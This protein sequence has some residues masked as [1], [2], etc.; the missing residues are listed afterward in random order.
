MTLCLIRLNETMK[1][2]LPKISYL[3]NLG[4]EDKSVK[5][6]LARGD[7]CSN[8]TA[9]HQ[10]RNVVLIYIKSKNYVKQQVFIDVY[11]AKI[12]NKLFCETL[13]FEFYHLCILLFIPCLFQR[14]Y[15]TKYMYLNA[16]HKCVY[17]I[18][19]NLLCTK[20]TKL[21]KPKLNAFDDPC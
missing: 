4:F 13:L 2:R 12:W 7:L 16:R 19:L 21:L 6:K 15:V 20:E 17:S 18:S 14:H 1:P 11:H 8:K 3:H 9:S 5:D 10:I